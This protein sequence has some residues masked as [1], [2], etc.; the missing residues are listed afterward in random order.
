MP[1]LSDEKIPSVRKKNGKTFVMGISI[2]SAVSSQNGLTRR[3]TLS[4]LFVVLV[5][6]SG[7]NLTLNS[8]LITYLT[9]LGL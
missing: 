7:P 6:L 4:F 2:E 1:K 8:N 9:R 3:N 5:R